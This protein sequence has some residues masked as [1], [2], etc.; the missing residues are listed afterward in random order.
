MYIQ[1]IEL[2]SQVRSAFDS[3][4]TRVKLNMLRVVAVKDVIRRTAPLD[5]DDDKY[6][7]RATATHLRTISV[8][9][10]KLQNGELY[11]LVEWHI[12]RNSS[13]R[14]AILLFL[15]SSMSLFFYRWS[16]PLTLVLH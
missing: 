3:I 13:V 2:T 1:V 16:V 12:T 10:V 6:F 15:L 11:E 14:S 7:E 8:I 9:L 4:L 5:H